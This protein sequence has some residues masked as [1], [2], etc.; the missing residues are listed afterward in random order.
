MIFTFRGGPRDGSTEAHAMPD[1]VF[2]GAGDRLGMICTD[3]SCPPGCPFELYQ[4]TGV[5]ES[6]DLGPALVVVYV[7]D[8][9]RLPGEASL[10]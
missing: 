8:D 1:G 4:L 7:G 9:F 10:D 3:P 6:T 5:Q 2:I